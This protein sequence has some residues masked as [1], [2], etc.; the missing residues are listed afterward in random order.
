M[1]NFVVKEN[2]QRSTP[3]LINLFYKGSKKNLKFHNTTSVCFLFPPVSAD[4]MF[5]LVIAFAS[6]PKCLI[7]SKST[8]MHKCKF[9]TKTKSIND[10]I[11][12][13]IHYLLPVYFTV[14]VATVCIIRNAQCVRLM[15]T[16]VSKNT[17]ES[18]SIVSQIQQKQKQLLICHL[19]AL[20]V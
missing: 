13:V 11:S 19:H 2:F 18:C 17:I 5:L 9:L 7:T 4:F 16:T 3:A 15:P 10:S 12:V 6:P 8:N 1:K 20:L 14:S